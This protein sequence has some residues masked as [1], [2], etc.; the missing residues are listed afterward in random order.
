[1]QAN[2]MKGKE[3]Q[4]GRIDLY[5]RPLAL[6]ITDDF[7]SAAASSQVRTVGKVP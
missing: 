5:S 4:L 6:L 3:E 1:M 2:K 7:Y